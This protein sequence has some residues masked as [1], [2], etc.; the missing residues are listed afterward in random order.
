MFL[1]LQSAVSLFTCSCLI[2]VAS[3]TPSNIGLVMTTGE[4]QVDGSSVRGNS[5]IFSGSLVSSGDANSNLQFSDG[6]NA[7]MNPG[8]TM[9]VYREHSVLQKGVA[10]QRGLDKHVVVANGLRISGVTPDAT[11]FIGVKDASHVEVAA[12]TGETEVRTAAGN[13]VARVEP[14][15]TLSFALNAAAGA[16]ANGVRLSGILRPHYLLT[17]EQT[18][19]TYQL[20]GSDLD[21]LVGASIQVTGTVLGTNSSAP[22]VVAVSNVTKLGAEPMMAMAQNGPGAAPAAHAPIWTG[23]SLIFLILV[24]VGGTLLG[25]GAAGVFSGSSPTPVTPATP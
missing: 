8:A 6:T 13:L 24:A 4:V 16:P 15:K 17:D 10:L 12:Q 19:I 21:A 22:A 23:A 25:L 20:Q 18:N 14:G 11:A 5:A 2:C 9:L 3:A 1:K 7:V